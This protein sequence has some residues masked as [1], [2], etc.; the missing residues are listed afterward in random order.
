LRAVRINFYAFARDT[1]TR[2]AKALDKNNSLLAIAG[3]PVEMI[4]DVSPS[5]VDKRGIVEFPVSLAPSFK[6]RRKNNGHDFFDVP[7]DRDLG[8]RI[9]NF[10]NG[11][12][13][14]AVWRLVNLFEQWPKRMIIL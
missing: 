8:F 5:E 14:G 9:P 13:G 3:A 6:Y 4:K 1:G 2:L 12:S 11:V 10:F 7:V